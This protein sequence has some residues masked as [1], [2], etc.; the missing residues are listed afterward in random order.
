[1]GRRC[2][3]IAAPSGDEDATVLAGI[4]ADAER[5]G[6]KVERADDDEAV[7]AFLAARDATDVVLVCSDGV[8]VDGSALAA[9]RSTHVLVLATD[10][11]ADVVAGAGRAVIAG[12]PFRALVRALRDGRADGNADGDITARELHNRL[13]HTHNLQFSDALET[14]FVVTHTDR[15]VRRQRR[16]AQRTRSAEWTEN[17]LRA[18]TAIGA[19]ALLV[20]LPLVWLFG[21]SGLEY[22]F[23][24]GTAWPSRIAPLLGVA[25]AVAGFAHAATGRGAGAVVVL[26]SASAG[27]VV[28][29]LDRFVD[30]DLG[31][32][33]LFTLLGL[34]LLLGGALDV[35]RHHYDTLGVACGSAAV[36]GYQVV[37]PRSW[38]WIALAVALLVAE[39]VY[40]VRRE[41]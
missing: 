37:G 18:S 23:A 22:A 35:L 3:L 12:A 27:A 1:M 4:L 2:A 9:C 24:S 32:G 13:A 41:R 29:L 28:G 20:S 6:Y 17:A 8:P 33:L 36:L 15:H 11:D 19:V 30:P 16:A 7:G 10:H 21:E 39:A 26:V 25:T 14:P 5:G 34:G 38:G 40:W 31:L